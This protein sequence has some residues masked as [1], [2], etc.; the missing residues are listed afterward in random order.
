MISISQPSLDEREQ[1]AVTTALMSGQLAQGARVREFEQ[2]FAAYCGVSHAVATSSGTTALWLA[3]LAHEIGPGDEVITTPFTFIASAN[4]IY[5][6]G[7]RPV[8]AD[9]EPETFNIDPHSVE[10]KITPRTRAIMPVHLFGQV[11]DMDALSELADRYD[12]AMI[13]D[14]CQ[15]HGAA[16]QGRKAGSFGTGC[17]SFY[18][19]KNMTTGEGGMITTDDDEIADRARLLRAHGM[20]QRY[21][22]E[23]IGYNFRMTEFQAALGIVQ[24]SKL[25]EFNQKRRANARYLDAGLAGIDSIIL[26]T[27]KPDHRHVFHQFTVRIPQQRDAFRQA[28]NA[29]GI[30]T[31]IYYPIPVHKQAPYRDRDHDS[32]FPFAEEASRQVLSLPV[33]PELSRQDMDMI[34]DA[35][36][37]TV[38]DLAGASMGVPIS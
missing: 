27:V 36:R 33:H 19:T 17:F 31:G 5:Y 16:V 11:C 3:L 6:T 35:V 13:E 21:Y 4:A 14:A 10:E 26:P 28:L 34:I 37:R 30:G 38:R 15:A 22:H 1:N 32:Q 12:L 25:E 2:Q 29:R 9:I 18:A 8:F 23:S 20:R 7:A 24:L